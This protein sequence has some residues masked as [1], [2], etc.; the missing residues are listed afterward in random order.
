MRNT[1]RMYG[2]VE[3]YQLFNDD[4]GARDLDMQTQACYILWVFPPCT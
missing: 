3:K 4:P 1:Q 2:L